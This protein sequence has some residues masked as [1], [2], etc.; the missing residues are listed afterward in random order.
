MKSLPHRYQVEARA[1][2]E[3]PVVLTSGGLE[4]LES[5]GPVEFDG[6]GDRWSPETLLVG[7]AA[8]CFILTFRAVARA[9]SLPWMQLRCDAEGVLDRVERTTRFT[10]VT[11]RVLLTVPP[12]TDPEKATQVLEKCERACLVSNSLVCPVTLEP[13]VTT[14]AA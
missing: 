10:G 12:G 5:A 6:P 4:P 2:S 11:L 9:A 14:G 7:A 1:Q 13:R 3:G 8:D